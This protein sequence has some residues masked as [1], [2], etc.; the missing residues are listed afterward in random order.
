M[1]NKDTLKSLKE[2]QQQMISLASLGTVTSELQS[3]TGKCVL[4]HI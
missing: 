3:T 4:V 1:S 2:I